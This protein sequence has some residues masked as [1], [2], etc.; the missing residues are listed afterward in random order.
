MIRKVSK[1]LAY[2]LCILL[3]VSVLTTERF[4]AATTDYKFDFGAGAVEYGYI[5]VNASMAYSRDRG[6]G[7]NTPGNMRNVSASGYGLTSEP[8]SLWLMELKAATPSM[9]TYRTDYMK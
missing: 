9:L 6:Y 2:A 1:T 7:F 5:G 3:M 4:E 8:F